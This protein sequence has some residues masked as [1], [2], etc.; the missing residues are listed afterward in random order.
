MYAGAQQMEICCLGK[1]SAKNISMN[2]GY[3]FGNLWLG[4]IRRLGV[5]LL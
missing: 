2:Q 5:N 1:E 3:M 4:A